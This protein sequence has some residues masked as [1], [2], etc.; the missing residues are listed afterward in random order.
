MFY[1]KAFLRSSKE[2]IWKFISEL[3]SVYFVL[4][5]NLSNTFFRIF[6]YS[7]YL[8]MSNFLLSLSD[9]NFKKRY[10]LNLRLKDQITFIMFSLNV[11]L[12]TLK[13]VAVL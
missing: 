9:K 4:I 12:F 10:R 13:N 6:F 7:D 8:S 3:K 1:N 11:F 2:A 5:F